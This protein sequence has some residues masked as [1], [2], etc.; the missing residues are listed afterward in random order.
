MKRF[1]IRN[2]RKDKMKFQKFANRTRRENVQIPLNRNGII[3]S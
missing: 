3:L 1:K 2:K